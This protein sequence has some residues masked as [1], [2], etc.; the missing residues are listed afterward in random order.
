MQSVLY[1]E[2]TCWNY[3][4]LVNELSRE[5]VMDEEDMAPFTHETLQ[6]LSDC[7]PETIVGISWDDL[8][9]DTI[10]SDGYLDYL[11]SPESYLVSDDSTGG[12]GQPG[13]TTPNL[14]EF[15]TFGTFSDSFYPL[16]SSEPVPDTNCWWTSAAGHS[17]DSGYDDGCSTA[18]PSP[19]PEDVVNWNNFDEGVPYPDG[20]GYQDDF[21]VLG[22]GLKTLMT[23]Y[24]E[25]DLHVSALAVPP[26]IPQP[27]PPPAPMTNPV[28]RGRIS[29]RGRRGAASARATHQPYQTTRQG[30]H[31]SSILLDVPA[32]TV[33]RR[34]SAARPSAPSVKE[35]DKIFCCSYQGC[36]KMYSKSSHLKAHLRR[37]TG[38]KPFACQWPGCGWRF[39]RSDELA[40]HKRSHSGIKPYRCQ[41]CDKRFSRSDHLAKHLKVHRREK[42]AGTVSGTSYRGRASHHNASTVVPAV[43]VANAVRA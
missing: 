22:V 30:R 12:T 35:E 38:E 5:A 20:F 15:G 26:S 6:K 10:G 29:L 32:S 7:E 36:N 25:E 41:V 31:K 16:P 37:H 18:T 14:P 17:P 33:P 24:H 34:Y 42:Q 39:S 1:G 40:R 11:F 3:A 27:P 8:P 2:R 13:L 43:P 19:S 28:P 9:L 23:G 4:V 21:V